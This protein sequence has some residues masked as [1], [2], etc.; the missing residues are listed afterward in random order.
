MCF[1]F[2][3][4]FFKSIHRFL[5][6]NEFDFVGVDSE[7]ITTDFKPFVYDQSAQALGIPFD[8]IPQGMAEAEKLFNSSKEVLIHGIY[9]FLLF[10][11][12]YFIF[13]QGLS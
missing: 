13:I 4:F 5:F 3:F 8:I 12:F 11:S 6:R 7:T 1:L 2:R 10:I 9:I